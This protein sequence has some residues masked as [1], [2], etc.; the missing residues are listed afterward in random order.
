MVKKLF[1]WGSFLDL[2][3]PFDTVHPIPYYYMQTAVQCN[4]GYHVTEW[5]S[6]YLTGCTQ[7]TQIDSWVLSEP[8]ISFGVPQGSVLAILLF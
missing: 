2:K 3:K 6:S 5:F 4:Q 7:S 8:K 1:S